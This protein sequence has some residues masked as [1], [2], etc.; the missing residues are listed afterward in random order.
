[1]GV[2]ASK[3]KSDRKYLETQDA[4]KLK[5][6][7]NK[8]EMNNDLSD[9]EKIQLK[10]LMFLILHQE[11]LINKKTKD[12]Q[13]VDKKE[14][15]IINETIQNYNSFFEIEEIFKY[16]NDSK[17]NLS[18]INQKFEDIFKKITRYYNIKKQ[19]PEEIKETKK[20]E[21]N[22]NN[23]YNIEYPVNFFLIEKSQFSLFANIFNEIPVDYDNN[24][25]N[26]FL[27]EDY[28]F[29][30]SN[31]DHSQYFV[32]SIDK[33]IFNIDFIFVKNNEKDIRDLIPSVNDFLKK[34]KKYA[35]KNEKKNLDN[36]YGN[37][38]YVIFYPINNENKNQEQNF[39]EKE[40]YD[41]VK[42]YVE[43]CE[44][45]NKFL[46]K[47]NEIK[48]YE[49]KDIKNIISSQISE[50]T[51]FLVY[52]LDEEI[53]K[54]ILDR[55]YYTE[56][57][58]PS[59]AKGEE[60]KK[61]IANL[62]I[63]EKERK[64]KLEEIPIKML[65][66]EEIINKNICLIDKDFYNYLI[67]KFENIPNN[68]EIYLLK[69]NEEYYLYFNEN[70]KELKINRINN[71]YI[72]STKEIENVQDTNQI[73]IK[74][75]NKKNEEP[76]ISV[77]I[78]KKINLFSFQRKDLEKKR[79][80][81]NI[82]YEE[83]YSLVNN[84]WLEQYND[85]YEM[86]QILQKCE[87]IKR[88]GKDTYDV[89]K[90]YLEEIP[91]QNYSIK[92]KSKG[93]FPRELKDSNNIL[94][95]KNTIYNDYQY[96]I[97]YE[98]IKNDLFNLLIKEDD[99]IDKFNIEI[100]ENK[101]YNIIFEENIIILID[102]SDN[103]LYV[104]NNDNKNNKN[105]YILKYIFKFNNS[106]IL[107]KQIDRLKI[108]HIN[109]YIN[110]LGLDL[111]MDVEEIIYNNFNMGKFINSNPEKLSISSFKFPPLIGSVNVGATCYMN[112]TLQ[113]F[114]NIDFLTNFFLKNKN[115]LTNKEKYDLG[116]EYLKV[117]L[118]LW[119]KK[120]KTKQYAPDDFKKKIGEKNPLFSGIAAN[121]SKDLVLFILETLHK[122]FNKPI[123]INNN[124]EQ[125]EFNG[126]ISDQT[127]EK[128]EYI[129][130]KTDYYNQNDSIIS[131]LFYGE[132]E[133]FSFCYNCRKTIYSFN[134]FNILIFPL[135][136]VRQY[137]LNKNNFMKGYVTLYDC[138]EQYTSPEEMSGPNQMYCNLCRT[139]SNFSMK[140]IIFKHPEVLIIIL[141]RGKG[142]QYQVPFQYPASFI[143]NNYINMNVNNDNYLNNEFIEYELISVI[144]HIGESSMSGHFIACCKSPADQNWYSY[145]D[146][147]V[148]KCADPLNIFGVNSTNSI[149]Y[150]LFYQIRKKN[151]NKF[152]YYLNGNVF[153]EIVTLYFKYMEK[154]FFLDTKENMIFEEIKNKMI[155]NYGI[156]DGCSFQRKNGE[157]IDLK[158]TVKE[159]GIENKEKLII[160]EN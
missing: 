88:E 143:L 14:F 128:E 61:I 145:N 113:C 12:N 2:S 74:E 52:V 110:D 28:I 131:K 160:I 116:S 24:L 66:Y 154:E 158:K 65:S 95:I 121:D 75:N 79:R 122:E 115:K 136:K 112:A 45:Y 85:H 101:I 119:N 67:N 104:Y 107:N 71:D 58:E 133:S 34:E 32:C 3:K 50:M 138:F 106:N 51:Q 40:I 69:I 149:P 126:Q 63:K 55:I 132:Q 68:N 29:I 37:I 86:R 60:R 18:K 49:N 43:L 7:I 141:N 9:N 125:N 15:Y 93:K 33:N 89:F 22:F 124:N 25:Y 44:K 102:N 6:T 120:N 129:K 42:Y 118:N 4:E 11:E 108:Q 78:I 46:S 48:K 147:I 77:N 111:T 98:I 30:E 157:K 5:I 97:Q 140:N 72:W 64:D 76:Y 142:L 146:A 137:I 17:D 94:P 35:L 139:N 16:F 54:K 123:V 21:L 82:I 105:N 1:M 36:K 57:L 100:N 134:I 27:I 31:N 150:V 73:Q 62:Q 83:G 156:K 90:E 96:P 114:S 20:Y 23:S 130:F 99:N 151:P 59:K 26:G 70:E 87:F 41:K 103:S 8:K 109:N 13:K 38:G 47:L 56:Y 53:F 19:N 117:I 152:D 81:K 159:N 148:T 10:K 153:E 91:E 127:N 92:V 135:E 144:T 80:L 155:E 39:N 84:K